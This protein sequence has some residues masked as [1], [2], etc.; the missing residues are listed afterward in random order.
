MSMMMVLK[1]KQTW[2]I[3]ENSLNRDMRKH[4]HDTYVD[5]PTKNKGNDEQ[6]KKDE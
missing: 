3:K 2:S 4:V 5:L 1:C 6:V